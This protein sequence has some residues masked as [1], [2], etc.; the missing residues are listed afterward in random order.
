[1]ECKKNILICTSRTSYL[2]R[3]KDREMELVASEETKNAGAILAL[4]KQHNVKQFRIFDCTSEHVIR[5]EKCPKVLKLWQFAQWYW[6]KLKFSRDTFF[7]SLL[8]ARYSQREALLL[9]LPENSALSALLLLLEEQEELSFQLLSGPYEQGLFFF[10]LVAPLRNAGTKDILIV[11]IDQD[12]HLGQWLFRQGQLQF[13]RLW[14]PSLRDDIE[15]QILP[16]VFSLLRYLEKLTN[17]KELDIVFFSEKLRDES[18]FLSAFPNG[19]FFTSDEITAFAEREGYVVPK[20][21]RLFHG[22]LSHILKPTEIVERSWEKWYQMLKRRAPRF[23]Q[24]GSASLLLTA[25]YLFY[26]CL[27]LRESSFHIQE[28]LVTLS[29]KLGNLNHNLKQVPFSTKQVQMIQKALKRSEDQQTRLWAFL[30]STQK[31][32]GGSYLLSSLSFSQDR[33]QMT[34]QALDPQPGGNFDVL[35]ASWGNVMPNDYFQ[36][37]PSGMHEGIQQVHHQDPRESG[38]SESITIECISPL[39]EEQ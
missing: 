12:M 33:A 35:L 5:I 39:K 13:W 3:L 19:S 38:D 17:V 16:A 24:A 14:L 31:V 21:E 2:Y 27:E 1:M 37:L 30:E 4:L 23:L 7:R 6:Q 29:Q 10:S 20:S 26:Q 36:I 22:L 34:V 18:A 25:S 9:G 32:L 11:S 8:R 15:G 28:T